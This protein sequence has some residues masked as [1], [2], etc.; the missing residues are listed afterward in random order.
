[1]KISRFAVGLLV[2][3]SVFASSSTAFAQG[4]ADGA[5]S[6]TPS[7]ETIIV[8][9]SRVATGANSPTPVTV[10]STEALLDVRPST[11][12]DTLQSIPVFA[13]SRSVLNN[14]FATGGSG[15]GNGVANQLNLRNVGSQR[16]LIL[17]DG[18]RLPSTSTNNVIDIDM[19]P[20]MMIERIETVTG[21][22]SAVYGSDAITGV[23]NFV[24]K[25]NYSGLNA[26][27]QYGLSQEGDATQFNA[28]VAAG[29]KLGDRGH[30]EA[31]YEFRDDKGILRR[32]QRDWH[33]R[34]VIAGSGTTA[35]PYI[36]V[37]NGNM[38]NR[39]FG[40]VISCGAAC[41]LNDQTFGTDGVL[42][43]FVHGSPV[44]VNGAT[45][46]GIEIGGD[47]GYLD[48]N[49]KAPLRSHQFFARFDYELSDSINFFAMASG[50]IKKNQ[51]YSDELILNNMTIR[52]TNAFLDEAYQDALAANGVTTFKFSRLVNQDR[53]TRVNFDINSKQFVMA[54]GFEGSI[55][56]WDWSAVYTHGISKLN[57]LMRNNVNEQ[58][59]RAA[60]DAVDVG[61]SIVC[62]IN[63]DAI[64]TNDDASCVP[65]NAFGPTATG[66]GAF[67]YALEDTLYKARTYLDDVSAQIAGSPFST[68]AGDVTVA[69]AAEWRE[70]RFK[71]VS[72]A[73]TNA[74]ANCAGL[75]DCTQG[76][77]KLWRQSF[78]TDSLMKQGVWEVAGE[79]E[80]P[81]LAD[82]PFA[83]RLSVNGAARYAKYSGIGSY[84][85]WKG[86]FSWQVSNDLRFRGTVSR[87][88]RAPTLSDLYASPATNLGSY[89]D[90]LLGVNVTVPQSELGNRNL[91]PEIGKTWTVGAVIKPSFVPGLTFTIDYYNLKISNAITRSVGSSDYFQ[92]TCYDSGGTSPACDLQ[93][94]PIDFTTKTPANA[95]TAFYVKPFNIGSLKTYGIDAEL[96]YVASLGTMPLRLRVLTAWQPHI[97]YITVDGAIERDQA[98]V[99][100][101]PVG[102]TASPKWRVTTEA[103]IEPIQNVRFDL[104][105]RWRSGLKFDGVPDRVWAGAD[106]IPA[107]GI[108]AL[109]M[110]YRVPTETMGDFEFFLNIQN[111]LNKDPD[112]ANGTGTA[113]NVGR[114]NGFAQSDDPLGRYFT[115]G[116]KVKF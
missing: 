113:S 111:L 74:L 89:P 50:N 98:G 26:K 32:S 112:A 63:A 86:G 43:P 87:D 18:R 91:T 82:M 68:W 90:L 101:G 76:S 2:G 13:G 22:A 109:N 14:P 46:S 28:G 62:G 38:P 83:Q 73:D 103:S 37:E 65:F 67:D 29:T 49:L 21:G 36:L 45:V 70:Q 116:A 1:M 35:L 47:G 33:T 7:G 66:G 97:K 108:L 27:V 17:M 51:L 31:S 6:E 56:G 81:L 11:L 80:V 84:W 114:Q 40:G 20:Q 115:V 8:T 59:L 85:A 110:S 105:Y 55:G 61:G 104:Q 41:S 39:A 23:V 30:I 16:N 15:A 92:R 60:L 99:A 100:F 69:L 71:S 24:T 93:E 9:G 78:A 75:L 44:T 54:G 94:R 77:T 79:A 53:D 3:S 88:I 102:M 34:P 64:T 106:G 10:V 72:E 4:A 96:N 5:V 19:I 25:K 42:R 95:A 57:T 107:Y 48:T 58:K 52:S 12:A